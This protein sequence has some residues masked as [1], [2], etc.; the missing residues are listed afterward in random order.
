MSDDLSAVEKSVEDILI[1]LMAKKVMSIGAQA[2]LTRG[3]QKSPSTSRR[4]GPSQTT[5]EKRSKHHDDLVN[6]KLILSVLLDYILPLAS[7]ISHDNVLRDF[8][9]TLIIAYLS[10]GICAVGP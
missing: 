9:Y 3:L 5:T 1:D 8:D 4:F 7:K 2:S 10:K 6:V